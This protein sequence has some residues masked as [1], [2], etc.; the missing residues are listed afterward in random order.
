MLLFKLT[1]TIWYWS[2]FAIITKF[3]AM[4]VYFLHNMRTNWVI[5]QDKIPYCFLS[6]DIPALNPFLAVAVI[7]H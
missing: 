3:Y 2:I 7:A 5:G 4:K 1:L 6:A